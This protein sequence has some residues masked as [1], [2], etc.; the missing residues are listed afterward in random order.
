MINPIKKMAN[1]D[2][3]IKKEKKLT[4]D[5][6]TGTA[7]YRGFKIR[8]NHF[9]NES[10]ELISQ[11]FF[12]KDFSNNAEIEVEFLAKREDIL[13]IYYI[14]GIYYEKRKN[15]VADLKDTFFFSVNKK[16]SVE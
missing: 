5:N 9:V 13:T 7:I 6:E 11:K 14:F 4:I 16:K 3:N 12:D 8:L 1:T 2:T 10:G 15:R